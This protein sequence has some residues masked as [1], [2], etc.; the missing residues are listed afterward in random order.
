MY[1]IASILGW[2]Q[3][4]IKHCYGTRIIVVGISLYTGCKSLVLSHRYNK[5][6]LPVTSPSIQSTQCEMSDS[7]ILF[8]YQVF[9]A[10][11]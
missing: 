9:I 1:I 11:A 6:C 3:V 5:P 2:K 10:Q 4:Q 7:Y 8:L